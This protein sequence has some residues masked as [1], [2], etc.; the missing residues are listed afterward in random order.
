MEIATPTLIVDKTI[1]ERNTRAMRDKAIRTDVQ[2]R[3]HVKTHKTIEIAHL[4][5]GGAI[6]PITV[7]TLAE[8]EFFAD[9]GFT[10][11]TY[12]V[13]FAAG[14][15][16]RA[17]SLARRVKTLN[18]LVD[19]GFTLTAIEEYAESNNVVFDLFLETDCGYHRSGVNPDAAESVDLAL[20]MGSSKHVR[21]RGLLTHGGHSYQATSRNEVA[22]VALEELAAVRRFNE[23][24]EG[25]GL[26]SL[27]RS[28]GSTPT[29]VVAPDFEGADEIRPGN[30]VFFDAFQAAIG[31]CA[32]RDCAATVLTSIIGT[33]PEEGRLIIDAG[34]LALSKDP[35]ATHL[36]PAA[37]YGVVCNDQLEPLPLTI[38]SLSQ[39]HGQV[40][41][42]EPDM[43]G[44]KYQ[45]GDRL[46]V[47]PNH[48]CLT[49]A[50][51][52]RYHVIEGGA[53]VDEWTP[54][55]GW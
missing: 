12:A 4:Q 1:V 54:A 41:L 50:M 35:G 6:G 37:G 53:I 17:A 27:T 45:V 22:A 51:F 33:Y 47:V 32:L 16:E 25:E 8:A 49:A 28:V 40:R 15:L 30:Y 21:F 38:Y 18:L 42:T 19:S 48:S 52:D 3:P 20:R 13:P 36:N 26:R 9:G 44:G 29:C 2:F 31:T 46:R 7:S 23:R 24:L 10:D 34:A 11:I 39:E 14:K 55:R 43:G 5:H